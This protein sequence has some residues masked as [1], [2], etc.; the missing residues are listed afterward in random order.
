[1]ST[2]TTVC[3]KA[4][5]LVAVPTATYFAIFDPTQDDDNSKDTASESGVSNAAGRLSSLARVEA[6]SVTITASL[7][8]LGELESGS[9]VTLELVVGN[10]GDDFRAKAES[11][12]KE[13]RTGTAPKSTRDAAKRP[14]M[15]T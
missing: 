12:T 3:C 13:Q 2:S 6:A 15:P 14:A 8:F 11:I 4:A 5:S 7:D 1:M 10:E 9:D